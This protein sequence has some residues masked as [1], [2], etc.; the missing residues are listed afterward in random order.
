MARV[1]PD[2]LLP[3]TVDS[4]SS[5]DGSS[6]IAAAAPASSEVFDEK[7]FVESLGGSR[8]MLEEVIGITL[9]DDVPRLLASLKDAASSR[10]S[11]ALEHAAHAIKGL[12]AELRAEPCRQAATIL[13]TS[14]KAEDA[15]TLCAELEK[16][17]RGLQAA[18]GRG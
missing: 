17:E 14:R 12:A 3:E 15:A 8:V 18:I 2:L 5:Q 10:N 16:L 11:A 1:I 13:E 4:A 9:K 7:A 6:P